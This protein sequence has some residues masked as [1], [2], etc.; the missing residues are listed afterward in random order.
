MKTLIRLT[1]GKTIFALLLVFLLFNFVLVPAAYPKFQTLDVLGSYT[2]HQAYQLITSYGDQGRQAYLVTELTLD[3]VYP[4][5]SAL[6]F[7]LLIVYSF[8]RAFPEYP[9]TTK[10]ALL[11]FAV[12]AA[13]YAENACIVTML[14]NY[15]RLLP[16]V[17]QVSNIFTVS[18]MALSP[19][20]LTFA[21][22]LVVWLVRSVR[23]RGQLPAAR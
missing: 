2:P 15:P 7:S 17:A 22:A 10:L 16:A 14:L 9:W 12:M 23:Q 18:K 13:D 11:P 21:V 6:L 4:F 5:T 19:L 1:T 8:Q 20:E 3:L